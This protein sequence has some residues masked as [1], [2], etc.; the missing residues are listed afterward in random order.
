[1]F[2]NQVKNNGKKLALWSPDGSVSY[3]GLNSYVDSITCGLTMLGIAKGT[4]VPIIGFNT[5]ETIACIL[6]MLKCGIA[7][8][9]IDSGLPKQRIIKILS[10]HNSSIIL[11]DYTAD[12]AYITNRINEFT[13]TIIHSDNESILSSNMDD[14]AYIIYTSGS[15]GEP[16][17]VQITQKNLFSF[18]T[19]LTRKIDL[20]TYQSIAS[21]ISIS[22]D[23]FFLESILPLCLGM[24]VY[25]LRKFALSNPHQLLQHFHEHTINTIHAVPSQY[26]MLLRLPEVQKSLSHVSCILS[27]GEALLP[28]TLHELQK[29]FPRAKIYDLYGP[30][31]TTIISTISD[32]SSS[33]DVH[34]G[35]PID[36]TKVYIMDENL[37]ALPKNVTGEICIA[38]PG[39]SIGY[40]HDPDLTSEKFVE[41]SNGRIYRTGDIGYIAADDMIHYISRADN[42]IKINGYRVELGEIENVISEIIQCEKLC[43]VPVKRNNN[44][45]IAAWIVDNKKQIN[46]DSLRKDLEKYLLKTYI[47]KYY[48]V[49]DDLIYTYN[50]KIDRKKIADETEK[51]LLFEAYEITSSGIHKT[52]EDIFYELAGYPIPDSFE[53]IDSLLYV[54]FLVEIEERFSFSFGDD[55]FFSST[56]VTV[57]DIVKYILSLEGDV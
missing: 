54:S 4:I 45:E 20:S 23:L 18:V 40:Y 50:G 12:A 39:V 47:P 51:K 8:I 10:R 44:T 53:G 36:G 9:P 22:F 46:I 7:Y 15:T 1:M 56:F 48:F 32:L 38:G 43:V 35:N 37:Q 6:A 25:L 27:V 55:L 49:V 42:Q 24:S 11:G 13:D 2:A 14:I 3:D 57:N 41:T 28:F 34:I 17:G 29:T 52:I 26:Q 30:T 21:V 33:H 31:E 5:I 16:K 19:G